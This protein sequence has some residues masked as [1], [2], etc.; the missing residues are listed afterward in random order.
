MT[1][2]TFGI[3]SGAMIGLV[4]LTDDPAAIWADARKGAVALSGGIGYVNCAHARLVGAAP[5]KKGDKGYTKALDEDGDG[6]ACEPI[7]VKDSE[8]K[9]D[10][11]DGDKAEADGAK[12][13]GATKKKS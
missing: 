11:A 3:V 4:L 13:D 6:I 1:L 2:V 10:K 8:S 9:P 5:L 12:A 7:I